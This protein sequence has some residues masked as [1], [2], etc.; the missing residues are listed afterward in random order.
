MAFA[1]VGVD[2]AAGP[3]VDEKE[4]SMIG[5][6]DEASTSLLL[7]EKH[8]SLLGIGAMSMTILED[9][10]EDPERD[11][12]CL[13]MDI[14]GGTFTRWRILLP[15]TCA[16]A[17]CP[18]PLRKGTECLLRREPRDLPLLLREG[19][20]CHIGCRTGFGGAS[21]NEETERAMSVHGD[22]DVEADIC[23]TE[24]KGDPGY[25]RYESG[26]RWDQ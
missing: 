26:V 5:F 20:T 22:R 24:I 14:H 1:A 19:V 21:G 13:D 9:R 18:M 10:M 8:S 11:G 2:T 6:R 3:I 7:V 4:I 12:W 17:N 16:F 23:K 25:Q 15:F